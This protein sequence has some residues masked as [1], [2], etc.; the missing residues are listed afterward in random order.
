MKKQT[1]SLTINIKKWPTDNE[2]A[3]VNLLL[4]PAEESKDG[5]PEIYSSFQYRDNIDISTAVWYGLHENI[6]S[7]DLQANPEALEKIVKEHSANILK[8]AALYRGR[9]LDGEDYI[10]IWGSDSEWLLYD[11][12]VSVGKCPHK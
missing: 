6:G 11:L 10:G 2:N 5:N 4:I 1:K 12:Q 3:S 7:V 9:E 8:F